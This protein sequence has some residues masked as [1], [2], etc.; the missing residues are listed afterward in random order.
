MLCALSILC[1]RLRNSSAHI[2]DV[3]GE[4]VLVAKLSVFD[5]LE[6]KGHSVVKHG[7]PRCGAIFCRHF[8]SEF[9]NG[10]HFGSGYCQG[11]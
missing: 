3:G 8:T 11:F 9:H 4:E 5:V 6:R 2:G 10:R 1:P 7:L